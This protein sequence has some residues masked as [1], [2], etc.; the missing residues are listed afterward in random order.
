[1]TQLFGAQ[2]AGS[3]EKAKHSIQS[4]VPDMDS[5]LRDLEAEIK[6]L[7]RE[8]QDLIESLKQTVGGMSD[9]RYGRFSNANLTE[10]VS[11]GLKAFQ[12]ECEKKS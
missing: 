8:E 4:I 12:A 9:L 1:M 5:A 6:A 10:E 7:E 2:S 3:T 11:D